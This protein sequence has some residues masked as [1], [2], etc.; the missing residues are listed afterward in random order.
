MEMALALLAQPT[1]IITAVMQ[2]AMLVVRAPTL[3][4]GQWPHAQVNLNIFN[5]SLTNPK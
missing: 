2:P 1:T 5:D 3:S 4:A